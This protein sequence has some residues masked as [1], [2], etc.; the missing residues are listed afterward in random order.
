M[1]TCAIFL[2]A[3]VSIALVAQVP[4]PATPHNYS[5]ELGFSYALPSDWDVVDMS[6]SLS[7]E[8]QQAQQRLSSDEEK[9]GVSCIR[10]ALTAHHGNPGSMV[11]AAALPSACVGAE[12]KDEDLPGFGTAA[13]Q[14]IEQSFDVT[15]PTIARYKLGTHSMWIARAKGNP[16]GQAEM[17]YTVE[18]VCTILKKGA[19]CWMALAAEDAALKTFEHGSVTLDGEAH[20]GLVPATAFASK[21]HAPPHPAPA[22]K[23]H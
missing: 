6:A 18:T 14:G 11:V 4:A 1:K 5:N 7:I 16:K 9:R 12:M 22:K 3:F 21:P 19:V 17:P 2:L 10:I 13:S 8:Q 15:E 23:T 20:V